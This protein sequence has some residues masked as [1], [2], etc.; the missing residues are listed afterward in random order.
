MAFSAY[1]GVTKIL[2][3]ASL[4]VMD[5]DARKM[6]G[7]KSF[8]FSNLKQGEGL[9]GITEFIVTKRMLDS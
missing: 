5:R 9:S 8:I 7:E 3:G 1:W 4:E 2:L 6:R